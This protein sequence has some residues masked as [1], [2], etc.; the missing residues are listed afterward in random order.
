MCERNSP[1]DTEVRKGRA[2]D[3][4]GAGAAIPL[5]SL[6]QRSTCSPWSSPTLEQVDVSE[7]AV[8]PW[9]ACTRLRA[10]NSELVFVSVF[11]R[12]M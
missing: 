2:G 1:A 4:L 6:V 11:Q 9:E 3:V 12:K 5:Q 8:T 10:H 7:E